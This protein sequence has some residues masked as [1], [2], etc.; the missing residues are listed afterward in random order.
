MWPYW[1][2]FVYAAVINTRFKRVCRK[3]DVS[4]ASI[5]ILAYAGGILVPIAVPLICK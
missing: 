3:N 5:E 1:K 2:Y 4:M